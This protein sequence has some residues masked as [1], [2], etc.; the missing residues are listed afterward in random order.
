MISHAE[1]RQFH[2]LYRVFLLRIVDSDVL[3]TRGHVHK[4]LGQ[5]IT[6]FAA[7]SLTFMIWKALQSA[8]VPLQLTPEQFVRVSWG[9]GIE[10]IS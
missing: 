5:L 3:Y 1:K 7:F 10:V 9:A 2:A 4:L 6:I 8:F